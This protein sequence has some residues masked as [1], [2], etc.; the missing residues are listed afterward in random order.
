MSDTMD[1][2]PTL[3]APVHNDRLRTII[4]ELPA[5]QRHLIER[6]F[7]GG[8]GLERAANEIGVNVKNAKGQLDEAFATIRATVL[9]E[10]ELG[11]LC[12]TML[13]GSLIEP[14][15]VARD[16]EAGWCD[17]GSDLRAEDCDGSVAADLGLSDGH[18]S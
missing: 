4:D 3:A 1:D 7:F 13:G 16:L 15:Q 17:P 6:M 2:Y 11:T 12:S 8:E 5:V 9:E 14:L 10:D 18:G